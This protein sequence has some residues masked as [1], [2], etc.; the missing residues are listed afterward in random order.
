MRICMQM[1]FVNERSHS[2]TPSFHLSNSRISYIFRVMEELNILE[3][4]YF[5]KA[6]HH[7]A[8]FD[9]LIEREARPSN[10][11]IVGSQ[12]TSLEHIRQELP[13]YGTTD[14][15]LPAV[16][17]TYSSNDRISH[18]EYLGYTLENG[19]TESETLPM[20][21]AEI[22]EA[23]SLIIHT[24]DR[25]SDLNID[26][27]YTIFKD[28]DAI[29]R[30]QVIK[31]EGEDTV[32]INRLMSL[33][34]D[35]DHDQ[36][37]LIH[38]HGAWARETHVERASLIKGIQ[39]FS[40][41]RGASSH[42]HNPFLALVSPDATELAGEAFGFNLIYS[43]NFLS[44]IEVDTYNVTRVSMGINPYQFKW[45]LKAG[46]IFETPEAVLVYSDAGLNGMS[47]TFHQLYLTHL[48][49]GGPR[50]DE[51]PVLINSWEANYFNFDEEK[52][53]EQA[54]VAKSLGI[55]LFVLDDGWFGQRDTDNG[56]LG[57]WTADERKLP[58]G[59]KGLADKIH[60]LGMDFGLWFEPEMLS[61]DT[62]LFEQHPDWI[63]G[64]P[65][66][67]IS[68][69]RNQYVLDF[70]N[71]A[72]IDEI[73][74]QMDVILSADYVDYVKWDMNRYISEAYSQHLASDQQG[75]VFHRYILGVYQLLRRFRQAFP[76]ILL[77]T[78][79]GGGGRYDAGMLKYARQNWISD[80]TDAVERLKIQYGASMVYPIS[81]MGTHVSE[82]PNHQVG[83][84]TSWKMR[85]DVALF[86]TF[87]YELDITKLDEAEKDIVKEQIVEFKRYQALIHHGK[88]YRLSS[89]FE[90]D[91]TA[92]M[93]VSQDQTDA[94][95]GVYTTRAVPN[96]PYQKVKLTGLNPDF[97]YRVKETTVV[98][99]NHRFGDDLMQ[100][101]LLLNTNQNAPKQSTNNE[102]S[103]SEYKSRL[104]YLKAR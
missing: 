45:Q 88:F 35:F 104:F 25:Y 70:T 8:S 56:S 26:L 69:G 100:I 83:R 77:E 101:G 84:M 80:D 79:A 30:R 82:V 57:N 17:L 99:T 41:T 9:Y 13:V 62:P 23:E 66:K 61:T 96:K 29:S 98:E 86:G 39:Q 73:F 24:K 68:H 46:D 15:R 55:D 33:S 47:Q 37:D 72:V 22:E 65:E 76:N 95:V 94:I 12:L 21:S 103:H 91:Q 87:G 10:N 31:N 42:Q 50:P 71:Q 102:V 7:Q 97:K 85:K 75:E 63:L 89:P 4:L 3:H 5:G 11:Q 27:I 93:V 38:L 60:E 43:G 48:V 14:F 19:K 32:A 78:C 44:Q 1:I 40:S 20:L 74:N 58:N 64:H 53:I 16:E 81:T 6:I 92:W 52:I 18:F 51:A 59:I 2:S 34:L 49:D 67:N 54:R 36:F 28:S 90:S